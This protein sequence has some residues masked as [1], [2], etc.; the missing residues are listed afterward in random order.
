MASELNLDVKKAKRATLFHDI[1][2]ALTHEQEGSH[3]VLGAHLLREQ[4]ED[5][6]II[7]AVA[8]HHGDVPTQT[9]IAH[10]VAAA[11]ALSGGRPG[12]RRE[13]VTAYMNRM[14]EL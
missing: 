1:G 2:K 11:D 4:H 12:A 3:A 7:N 10:L 8:S 14:E 6:E 9:P 5:P 13:M